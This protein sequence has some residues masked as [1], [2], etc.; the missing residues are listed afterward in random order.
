MILAAVA[1]V[2]IGYA[3]FRFPRRDLAAPT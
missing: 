2:A 1:A 3:L